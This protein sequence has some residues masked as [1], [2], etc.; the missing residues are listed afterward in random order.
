VYVC[1]G[2]VLRQDLYVAQADLEVS[3]FLPQ[4]LECWDYRC[5]TPYPVFISLFRNLGFSFEK[6]WSLKICLVRHSDTHMNLRKEDCLS[7][8]VQGQPGQLTTPHLKQNEIQNNKPCL[9]FCNQNF[10]AQ[11]LFFPLSTGLMKS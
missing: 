8:G 4:P 3:I 10:W 5:V 7:S 9:T 11:N 6:F 1:V 2:A